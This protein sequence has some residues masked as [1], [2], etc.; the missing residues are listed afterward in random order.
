VV[1]RRDGSHVVLMGLMGSG[2]ST[3]GHL[4]ARRL[5]VPF[6]DND[7]ALEA[8]SGRSARDIARSDGADAL[9]ALEARA[10]VDALARPGPAVVAAAASVVEQP[11]VG[12][13]LRGHE[14]VYLHATPEV[15][16][17]RVA[18]PVRDDDHR[19]FVDHEAQALLDAQY[20]ARDPR[21]R[22][23]AGIVVDT[24]ASTPDAI[25]DQITQALGRAAHRMQSES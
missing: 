9:H 14:V 12:D 25:V 16:A 19:P 7:E 11:A 21:Y 24:S 20:A 13:A 6:V 15:L 10:L 18:A 23:V 8:R 22:A 5:G 1:T 4:L 3:I 2:K 17:A